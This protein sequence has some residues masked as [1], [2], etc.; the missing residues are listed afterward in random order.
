M[1]PAII[2]LGLALAF[3]GRAD[4]AAPKFSPGNIE[5]IE[6]VVKKY[7][8]KR[9][10]LNRERI[11]GISG[12]DIIPLNMLVELQHLPGVEFWLPSGTYPRP[13]PAD[14]QILLELAQWPIDG[15]HASRIHKVEGFAVD[16]AVYVS[17]KEVWTTSRELERY[18]RA[19]A[20]AIFCAVLVWIA[21]VL[22]WRR[23]A[24]CAIIEAIR[25]L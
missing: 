23:S 10:K 19:F 6:G 14:A 4:K 7:R 3:N 9:V 17:A 22:H 25:R 24:I 5:S 12:R 2:L 13:I 8:E 1:F 15:L 16:G 21:V 18:Y 11:R 20:F